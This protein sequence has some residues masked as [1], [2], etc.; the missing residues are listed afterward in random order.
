[1]PAAAHAT[2]TTTI[3]HRGGIAHRRQ[4]DLR[5]SLQRRAQRR[6]RHS[7]ERDQPRR[8]GGVAAD[9]RGRRPQPHLHRL[10]HGTLC[11]DARRLPPASQAAKRETRNSDY[12]K[13]FPKCKTKCCAAWSLSSTLS[14]ALHK[15]RVRVRVCVC[16]CAI[17]V[18]HRRGNKRISR[19]RDR[20]H[21]VNS[22]RRVVPSLLMR[23]NQHQLQQQLIVNTT[24][25]QLTT[26]SARSR[27][28]M[29]G[30]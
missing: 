3:D 24:W 23:T 22:D 20:D 29:L 21:L 17:R 12:D 27:K 30:K 15:L 26:Y 11:A 5:W 8:N 7:L 9:A 19:A 2:T 14:C 28:D 13:T 18:T 4:L 6:L 25:C 16:A 1:M 10:L